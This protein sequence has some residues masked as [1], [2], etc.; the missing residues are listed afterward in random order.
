[1]SQNKGV[2]VTF[3]TV[4]V[5]NSSKYYLYS[6]QEDDV[7]LYENKKVY[8][9]SGLVELFSLGDDGNSIKDILYENRFTAISI[10]RNFDIN[11]GRKNDRNNDIVVRLSPNITTTI[12]ANG[13]TIYQ[14]NMGNFTAYPKFT[15]RNIAEEIAENNDDSDSDNDSGSDSGN[16]S[17]ESGKSSISS[18]GNAS[19]GGPPVAGGGGIGPAGGAGSS[20]NSAVTIASRTTPPGTPQGTPPP[21]P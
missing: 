6:I 7:M 10:N 19:T 1:M 4:G 3:K 2:V 5:A 21:S 14:G 9:S 13:A 12:K 15:K 16:D 17:S 20:V 11:D 8:G 18:F